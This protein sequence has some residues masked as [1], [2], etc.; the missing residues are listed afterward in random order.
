MNALEVNNLWVGYQGKPVIKN[1]SL[2][3]KKGSFLTIVGPNGSGKS[4]LLKSMCRLLSP[5]EGEVVLFGEALHMLTSKHIAQRIA[6]LPQR[7]EQQPE[8]LVERLVTYGRHPHKRWNQRLSKE[9][10]DIV[11]WA[12]DVTNLQGYRKRMLS[13]L[14]GGEVQRAW[15]AMAL[16]Q[17][18]EVLFLDE[19]TTYLDLAHQLDILETIRELNQQK[20]ITVIMVHHD[21]NQAV[22]YSD[23]VAALKHGELRYLLSSQEILNPDIIKDVFS[24]EGDVIHDPHQPCGFFIPKKTKVHEVHNK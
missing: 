20:G 8:L 15:L 6:V 13:Q 2:K 23:K 24:V 17:Q 5:K 9:D 10:R 1:L 14:S 12:L 16:A 7:H 21:L 19:P 22:R 11:D 4:T 3:V 18:P